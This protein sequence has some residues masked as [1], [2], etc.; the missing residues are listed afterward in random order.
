MLLISVH[1]FAHEDNIIQLRDFEQ[2]ALA[3]TGQF[4]GELIAAFKP[5]NPEN[6]AEIPD[7]IHLLQFPSQEAFDTYC[8]SPESAVLNPKRASA[9][10][11]TIVYFS[12]EI[13]DY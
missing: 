6:S 9:I 1:L 4:G 11:K 12:E 13:I 8:N 2:E 7:E 3:V 10:R 5:A